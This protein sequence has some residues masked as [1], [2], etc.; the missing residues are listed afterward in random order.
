MT[1]L[2]L[3][4][5]AEDSS[6][7]FMLNKP[8]EKSN[9]NDSMRI[10]QMASQNMYDNPKQMPQQPQQAQLQQAQ[11]AQLQQAQQAQQAQLSQQ[12][13]LQLSQQEQ[14]QLS[15]QQGY[16]SQFMQQ[17]QAS[18]SGQPNQPKRRT[19]EYSFWDRMNMKKSEVIKLALFALVIV[20]GISID[21]IGTHY[22]LKY[23]SENVL[24]DMQ[25]FLLRLCYPII[26][27][28]LLWVLKSA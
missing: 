28:L 1:E 15:Q 20:L 27:F 2:N 5:G 23:V 17:A 14:L 3:L 25:E 12:A 21:R 24:T 6:N 26:V 10:Y 19:Q 13:Q 22:I 4:Y 9:K 18:P 11:Q 8:E 7:D 16:D